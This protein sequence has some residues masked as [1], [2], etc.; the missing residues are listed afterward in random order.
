MQLTFRSATLE[1]APRASRLVVAGWRDSYA[2]FLPA[3]LLGGLE[4]NPHHDSEAWRNLIATRSARTWI[5]SE[6]GAD[7]GIARFDEDS[8]VPRTRGELTT[9]YIDAKQRNR[10]LGAVV[11]DHVVGVARQLG[12]SPIGLCVL[13]SNAR[14]C[15]FYER[16]GARPIGEREVFEWRD[17]KI[18][19]TMYVMGACHLRIAFVPDGAEDTPLI[20]IYGTER[21]PLAALHAALMKL[22]NK[23]AAS[24][25]LAALDGVVAHNATLTLSAGPRNLGINL[26]AD[27]R[28][29]EWI[30]TRD[31]FEDAALLVEPLLASPPGG[32]Q[33]LLGG[34]GGM[35]WQQAG[36][37]GLVVSV[38]EDGGW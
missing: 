8:S 38:S 18:M 21:A 24:I 6:G 7:I 23:Q 20:R 15:A 3:D 31:A 4:R 14:G 33:W 11:L 2:G 13:T 28:S 35:L 29:F 10:G 25:A 37:V 34:E 26:P 36:E 17:V 1:D 9:L 12:A 27:G 32:F 19:E 16:H 30:A 5:V 22:A